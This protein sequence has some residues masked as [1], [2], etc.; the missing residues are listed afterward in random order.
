MSDYIQTA[1][2]TDTVG[3]RTCLAGLPGNPGSPG[4]PGGPLGPGVPA[5]EVQLIGL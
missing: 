2:A 5:A 3:G 1:V 4:T